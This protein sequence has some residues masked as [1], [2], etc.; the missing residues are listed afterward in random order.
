[1]DKKQVKFITR[2]LG[3]DFF[4]DLKK[5][6]LTGG[7]MKLNTNTATDMNEIRISLQIVPRTVLSYLFMHLKPKEVGAIIKLD[8]P[9]A[10]NTQLYLNK[11]SPD[12]YSGEIIQKGKEIAKMKYRSLPGVGLIL[13]STLELYDIDQLNEIKGAV[14]NKEVEEKESKLQEII[15]ERLYLNNLISNVIE[16]K[17]SQRDAIKQLVEA[18]LNQ[19]IE[20]VNEPVEEAE[21]EETEPE[22]IDIEIPKDKKGKLREFIE[23][24]ES[25]KVHILN[26]LNKSEIKCPYCA[27]TLYNG[28]NIKLCMCYGESRNKEITIQ[29]NENGKIQL[30]FPKDIDIENIEML[31]NMI[32]GK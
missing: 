5:S 10:E 21:A 17:L 13:M 2:I 28:T 24:R 16:Q 23:K 19:S 8:L 30:K 14:Q 32:K 4:E 20:K 12:N 31:L 18:R 25:K 6:E 22:E 15:N 29:K 9:F 27:K 26:P 1:M 7:I 3:K 11:M